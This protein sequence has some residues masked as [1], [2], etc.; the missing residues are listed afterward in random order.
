LSAAASGRSFGAVPPLSSS[1]RLLPRRLL[2]RTNPLASSFPFALFLFHFFHF[3]FFISFFFPTVI[4]EKNKTTF[5]FIYL[6][7]YILNYNSFY[8]FLPIH[9]TSVFSFRFVMERKTLAIIHN[10]V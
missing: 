10:K 5:L 9:G 6:F 7:I 8:S 2:L 1:A 4:P 3:V